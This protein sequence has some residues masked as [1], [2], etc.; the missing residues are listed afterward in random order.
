[1]NLGRVILGGL[2]AG[3]IINISE[4]F[5][6]TVV[7][8]AQMDALLKTRNMPALGT[9]SIATF[10]FLGFLLGIVTIWQYAA[11]RP[12]YGAGPGAAIM[13]ALIVFF[14]A[15]IYPTAGMAVMGFMSSGLMLTIVGWGLVEIVIASLAGAWLYQE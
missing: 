1:V 7:I 12:R 4:G 14:L 10:V 3:L 8:G 15:Y 9:S 5:F 11:I 13:A 6:N 2:L